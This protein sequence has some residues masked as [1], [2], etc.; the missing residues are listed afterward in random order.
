M[1]PKMIGGI[2]IIVVLALG[3]YTYQILSLFNFNPREV[4]IASKVVRLESEEKWAEAFS[5]QIEFCEKGGMDWCS[6]ASNNRLRAADFEKARELGQK[7]C[8]GESGGGCYNLACALCLLG[9][10]EEAWNALERSDRLKRLAGRSLR[11]NHA[12]QDTDLK[13]LWDDPRFISLVQRVKTDPEA[14]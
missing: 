5:L 4:W 12:D 7:S 6:N 10:K 11:D 14:R 8:A 9:K 13:C 1:L 2:L 3:Q